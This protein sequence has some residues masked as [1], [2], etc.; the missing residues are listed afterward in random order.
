VVPPPAP[1][2]WAL[3]LFGVCLPAA[4]LVFELVTGA[5]AEVLFDPLPTP[6][7]VL[8]VA[9]VPAAN[10]LALLTLER[11]QV[12]RLELSLVLNGVALVAGA[13]YTLLFLPLVPI[14]LVAALV[15]IGF[16]PLAP[17]LS[18][19]CAV[20][21]R[22]RLGRTGWPTRATRGAR[23]RWGGPLAAGALFLLAEGPLA[24]TQVGLHLAARGTEGEQR[25]GLRVLRALG[26]EDVLLAAGYDG[27]RRLSLL[28]VLLSL[29]GESVDRAAAQDV[30]Y[31][32]T[33][34]PF[35]SQPR[36]P[37]D[38]FAR[39]GGWD[40]DV[41]GE[42]VGG[43]VEGL[44]LGASALE[45]SVDGEAALAYLEWTME[46]RT[47]APGQ[48]EGR[49]LLQLPPGGVVSRVTL[50]IDGE[51]REAA[52]AGT[53]QVKAAYESVVKRRMDPLLVTARPGDR[54]QVQAFPVLADKPMRVKL[55]ITAPLSLGAGGR[56]GT[57]PL[58]ALL[59]RNFELP[60]DFRHVL[61][62]ESRQP[63]ALASG[64]EVL[65]RGDGVSEYLAALSD[66]ALLA[67]SGA[68]VVERSG[69][70]TLAWAAD[71]HAPG[72]RVEQRLVEEAPPPPSR[73]LLV[74]DGSAGMEAVRAPL[75][76]ALAAVPEGVELGVLAALDG[77]E[78]LL[79]PQAADAAVRARAAERVLAL[80]PVGGQD[81]HAALA[82]AWELL[83][84]RGPAVVLWVHGPQ[85]LAPAPGAAASLLALSGPRQV[86]VLDVQV[87]PGANRVADALPPSAPV[88]RLVPVRGLEAEL[89][90]LFAGFGRARP[91][92]VRTRAEGALL[93]ASS[94]GAWQTSAHLARLWARDEVA[95]LHATGGEAARTEAQAL[96][97]R[98]QLVTAVTGAVVLERAE[99][100]RDAGLTPVES[101]TVPTVPEPGTWLMLGVAAALLAALAARQRRL[102]RGGRPA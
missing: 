90:A 63:L 19:L 34:R 92:V 70:H 16:M 72:T 8:L 71:V 59:E 25:L 86:E 73:L 1:R 51:P 37:A 2:H 62:V 82:R 9:C 80:S 13:L 97:A 56:T 21:L 3:W 39:W 32:V 38:R 79:P 23:W 20:L 50:Y 55:G 77:V 54:V 18:L 44:S 12:H 89:T 69:A 91:R 24:A 29:G 67:P 83:P 5:C 47:R 60:A 61:R 42:H 40:R 28:D 65:R 7:H 102:A 100:Y 35:S 22:R 81:T 53:G 95:R 15:L 75:A 58:P 84:A 52:F 88:R 76:A 85:P 36:P 74:L 33:G 6:V 87:A 27:S 57:L 64:G 94:S 49:M 101:G 96:G 4:T 41:A 14:A 99:Q 66:A 11:R 98:Y 78:E 10:A 31:R 43:R 17:A 30:Y 93:A 26:R 68:L 46:L 48:S 45:G